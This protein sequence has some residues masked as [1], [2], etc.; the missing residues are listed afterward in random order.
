MI[1]GVSNLLAEA[2]KEA[3]GVAIIF[4]AFG[5]GALLTFGGLSAV[6]L[7]K[8]ILTKDYMQ[9]LSNFLL[10]LGSLLIMLLGP[11]TYVLTNYPIPPSPESKIISLVGVFGALFLGLIIMFMGIWV[12]TKPGYA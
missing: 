8:I 5:G 7:V 4:I 1:M 10:C 2:S 3:E 11:I 6:L 12:S 9:Y